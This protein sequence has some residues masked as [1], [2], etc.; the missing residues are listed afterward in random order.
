MRAIIPKNLYQNWFLQ[1]VQLKLIIR[2]FD[3]P[4]IPLPFQLEALTC[5]S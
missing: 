1:H 4:L 2:I 3:L 5:S